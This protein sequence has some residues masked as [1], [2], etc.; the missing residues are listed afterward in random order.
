MY[1]HTPNKLCHINTLLNENKGIIF[2]SPNPNKTTYNYSIPILFL[3]L[4]HV[5]TLFTLLL[6]LTFF[7]AKVNTSFV[8]IFMSLDKNKLAVIIAFF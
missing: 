8:T 7:F 3:L 4:S 2:V 6:V 1:E 5:N